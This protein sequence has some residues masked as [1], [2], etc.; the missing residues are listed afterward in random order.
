MSALIF[1]K[2][3]FQ[4]SFHVGILTLDCRE[5]IDRR[6]ER[7]KKSHKSDSHTDT[8]FSQTNVM[9]EPIA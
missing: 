4:A 2:N 3:Q 1:I 8:D 5:E 7:I 9:C 6:G